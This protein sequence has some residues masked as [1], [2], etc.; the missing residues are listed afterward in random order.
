MPLRTINRN[1]KKSTNP[2]TPVLKRK[3]SDFE[4]HDELC[5]DIMVTNCWL[6]I[7]QYQ[8]LVNTGTEFSEIAPVN[9]LLDTTE[10]SSKKT[11]LWTTTNVKSHAGLIESIFVNNYMSNNLSTCSSASSTIREHLK[12]NYERFEEIEV[13]EEYEIFKAT[14]K[15]D[16]KFCRVI[17]SKCVFPSV[18]KENIIKLVTLKNKH[19][20]EI[21]NCGFIQQFPW[22]EY[23]WYKDGCIA[24]LIKRGEYISEDNIINLIYG[25]LDAILFLK[26]N[27][28]LFRDLNP[29]NVMIV[30]SKFEYEAFFSLEYKGQDSNCTQSL[31]SS[32]KVLGEI[33]FMLISRKKNPPLSIQREDLVESIS[34]RYSEKIIDLSLLLMFSDLSIYEIFQLIH[35]MRSMK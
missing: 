17:V 20:A 23:K 9:E 19:I 11:K 32:M 14:R 30:K 7:A 6:P 22:F 12:F 35:E 3:Y 29:H 8:P 31:S 10:S 33:I 34:G 15:S 25:L 27:R 1:E 28:I 16:H 18:E 21:T 26:E 2:H 4:D 13:T 5:D 24:N